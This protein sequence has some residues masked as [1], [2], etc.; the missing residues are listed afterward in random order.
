MVPT[1]QR[2][3]VA[4]NYFEASFPKCSRVA[5]MHSWH[6]LLAVALLEADSNVVSIETQ[7]ERIRAANGKAYI[8]DVR[9]ETV[10]RQSYLEVKSTRGWERERERIEPL[11]ADFARKKGRADHGVSLH[12]DLDKQAHRAI[13]FIRIT[14]WVAQY[15]GNDL[16]R[17][18]KD[19]RRA[20]KSAPAR[21]IQEIVMQLGQHA[22]EHVL[23]AIAK[24]LHGGILQFEGP[25]GFS[26]ST[27]VVMP[28][29][30]ASS[31]DL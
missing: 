6:E 5:E 20:L 22:S 26:L 2:L 14:R 16:N 28:K 21:S 23:A 18:Q 17:V 13:A 8:P 4:T 31:L 11:L 7:P 1:R 15:A 9:Y 25:E 10:A 30:G 12:E 19:V 24:D 3:K 29:V 27:R